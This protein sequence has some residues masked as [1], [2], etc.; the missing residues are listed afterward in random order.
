MGS[1][2]LLNHAFLYSARDRGILLSQKR[3]MLS[4]PGRPFPLDAPGM[5]TIQYNSIKFNYIYAFLQ[6]HICTFTKYANILLHWRQLYVHMSVHIFIYYI[7]EK[8]IE[9]ITEMLISWQLEQCEE[10]KPG[11]E[12][13]DDKVKQIKRTEFISMVPI[14]YT[15]SEFASDKIHW[16]AFQ[17][18]IRPSFLQE[19]YTSCCLF[20]YFSF[21]IILRSISFIIRFNA[22]Y[23]QIRT[24]EV[25]IEK[26]GQENKTRK[27]ENTD[28]DDKEN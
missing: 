12:F 20:F 6:L 13:I 3:A 18:G 2:K 9:K 23:D 10:E 4:E 8:V 22:K 1:W 19:R 17:M 26:I 16:L 14:K 7:D 21:D 28:E 24:Q 27:H 15:I 5:A 25:T 11:A